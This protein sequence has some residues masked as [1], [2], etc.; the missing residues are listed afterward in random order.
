MQGKY[1]ILLLD[2]FRAYPM[3]MLIT[4]DLVASEHFHRIAMV[5]H[6][7]SYV[8]MQIRRWIAMREPE[9]DNI[10]G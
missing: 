10:A 4:F 6:E 3:A 1:S 7:K 5:R 8:P 9:D 2:S